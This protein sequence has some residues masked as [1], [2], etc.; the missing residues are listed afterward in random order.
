MSSNFSTAFVPKENVS[1][2]FGK[3]TASVYPEIQ[4]TMSHAEKSYTFMVTKSA[5]EATVIPFDQNLQILAGITRTGPLVGV[6]QANFVA[7]ANTALFK[8]GKFSVLLLS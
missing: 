5:L 8:V 3:E 1:H 6:R 7:I 2:T 4:P